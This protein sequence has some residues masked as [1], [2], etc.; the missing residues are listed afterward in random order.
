MGIH[1]KYKYQGLDLTSVLTFDGHWHTREVCSSLMNNGFYCIGQKDEQFAD[2]K[3]MNRVPHGG[4]GVLVW[5]E[6]SYGQRTRLHFITGKFNAHK[7][8][9]VTRSC[10]PLLC[11][12][13][14]AIT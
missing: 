2:V 5:A 12:S 8:S 14:A 6:I 13:A 10:G 9:T 11:H 7:Y 3:V 1:I 4:S